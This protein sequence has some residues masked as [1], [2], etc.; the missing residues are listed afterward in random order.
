MT[1]VDWWEKQGGIKIERA[2][3]H[4]FWQRYTTEYNRD[5]R[6]RDQLLYL[7]IAAWLL[8]VGILSVYV[9]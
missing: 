6:R 5:L 2:A 9:R 7:A 3:R 4:A 8:C 1:N